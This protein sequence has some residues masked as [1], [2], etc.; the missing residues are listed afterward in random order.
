MQEKFPINLHRLLFFRDFSL[1]RCESSIFSFF[2]Q[3]SSCHAQN[4]VLKGICL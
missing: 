1:K 4:N 3:L 2:P